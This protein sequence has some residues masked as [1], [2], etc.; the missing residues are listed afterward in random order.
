MNKL[1]LDQA[2]WACRLHETIPINRLHYYVKQAESKGLYSTS[3]HEGKDIVL[4]NATASDVSP[5]DDMEDPAARTMTTMSAAAAAHEK[6]STDS[7]ATTTSSTTT[8]RTSQEEETADNNTLT[9]TI[10]NGETRQRKS[11]RQASFARIVARREKLDY[12]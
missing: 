8:T 11:S 1:Q 4:E 6:D 12:S 7:N 2:L 5:L 10:T 9:T 3:S